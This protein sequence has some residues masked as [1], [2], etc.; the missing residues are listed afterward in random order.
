MRGERELAT[1]T[2]PTLHRIKPRTLQHVHALRQPLS[3]PE[4]LLW[5]RLRNRQLGGLK[6]R[7]QH[8]IGSYIVDFYCAEARLVIELD[9][10]SHTEQ[11]EYDAKRTLWIGEQGHREIRF[12]N[13]EVLQNLDGVLQMILQ[14]CGKTSPSP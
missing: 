12:W 14:A 5:S 11:I 2:T 7:R 6:F 10:D 8:P 4:A 3:P 9:G 13:R 1:M